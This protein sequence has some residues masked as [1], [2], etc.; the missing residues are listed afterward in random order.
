MTKIIYLC[1]RSTKRNP[2][3]LSK[4]NKNMFL[5]KNNNIDSEENRWLHHMSILHSYSLTESEYQNEI[6]SEYSFNSYDDEWL[7]YMSDLHSRSLTPND[8]ENSKN[9]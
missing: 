5:K 7:N 3:F 1:F 6:K 4:A 8:L 2:K 9:I